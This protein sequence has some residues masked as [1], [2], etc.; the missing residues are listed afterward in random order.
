MKRREW[1]EL[2][3]LFGKEAVDEVLANQP[4]YEEWA[5][6]HSKEVSKAARL[7][8]ELSNDTQAAVLFVKQLDAA[9]KG[10]LI[11]TMLRYYT[12]R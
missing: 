10:A 6:N 9:L 12:T 3:E 11:V 4:H 8:S 2:R 1:I 7:L 5:F